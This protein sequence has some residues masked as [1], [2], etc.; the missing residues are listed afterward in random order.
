MVLAIREF[1]FFAFLA[2]QVIKYTGGKNMRL[3]ELGGKEIINLYNGERLGVLSNTDLVIDETTGEIIC[4]VIPK[5]RIPYLLFA[6]RAKTEVS[7]NAIKNRTGYCD[8][9]YGRSWSQ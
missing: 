8:Y 1:N 6:E 9:R 5:R 3:S 7:W 4:L 2:S